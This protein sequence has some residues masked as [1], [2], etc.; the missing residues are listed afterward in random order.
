MQLQPFADKGTI[1]SNSLINVD[2]KQYFLSNGIYALEQVGE[3]NQIRLGG[4]ISMAIKDEFDRFD[5]SKL[6]NTI[7]LH[8]QNK[9]QTWFYFLT[10]VIIIITLYG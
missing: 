5:S 3:L 10:L 6:K 7:A 9:S 4:E 8:Y 2:N 1:A